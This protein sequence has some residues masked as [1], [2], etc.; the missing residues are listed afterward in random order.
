MANTM[1]VTYHWARLGGNRSNLKAIEC[2]NKWECHEVASDIISI[3]GIRNVRMNFC[4]RL[5]KGATIISHED[6][7]SG[8]Y[9][10]M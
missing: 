2:M 4:G 3:C 5:Q 8:K 7:K 1:Y 10:N 9:Y 6:Y